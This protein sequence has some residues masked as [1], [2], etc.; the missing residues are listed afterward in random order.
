MI[1][2][3]SFMYRVDSAKS[4]LL[5]G[6]NICKDLAIKLSKGIPIIHAWGKDMELKMNIDYGS[7][8]G[9]EKHTSKTYNGLGELTNMDGEDVCESDILSGLIDH[10]LSSADE[11]DEYKQSI[12]LR[13]L[14]KDSGIS[15]SRLYE[16]M[17]EIA[18]AKYGE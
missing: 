4:F 2:N 11:T 5:E 9:V 8:Y 13:I 6:E 1:N 16:A 3:E 17:D 7:I 14:S 15:I 10:L 18:L 12:K